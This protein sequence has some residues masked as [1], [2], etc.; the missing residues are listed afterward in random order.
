MLSNPNG[1]LK[2]RKCKLML[3][4][5]ILP[6]FCALSDT[7]PTSTRA[8]SLLWTQDAQLDIRAQ[9]CILL[10]ARCAKVP[11]LSK[12]SAPTA[13]YSTT[14]EDAALLPARYLFASCCEY[15]LLHQSPAANSTSIVFQAWAFA[16]QRQ[17]ARRMQRHSREPCRE[18]KLSWVPDASMLPV[19]NALLQSPALGASV[20]TPWSD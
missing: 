8:A 20:G 4:L 12:D 13:K 19:Q 16:F 5:L 1:K 14:A 11:N 6:V 10:E 9:A 18:G 2:S 17:Q 3:S 7:Y 15:D